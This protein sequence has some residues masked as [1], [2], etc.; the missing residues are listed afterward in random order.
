GSRTTNAQ[1]WK[2]G[3]AKVEITPEKPM[4]MSGYASRGK[5]A[6]GK[7]TPLWAKSLALQDAEGRKA[8]LV[9]MDL[10]G[11]DRGLGQEIRKR[12]SRDLGLSSEAIALCTSHTHCGPVVGDNL[13]SMYFLDEE[14]RKLVDEYAET[15]RDKIIAAVRESVG[16]LAPAEL[17]WSSGRST[18]AVNRR[19]NRGDVRQARALG[20]LKGPVDHDV[21]VLSVRDPDGKLKAVVFG[22]AC[23]AT[24][25]SFQQWCGDW[26]G[27]AQAEVEKTHPE[28]VAMFWAG[29]GADQNPLPRRSVEL[30]QQYGR[31]LAAAVEVELRGTPTPVEPRLTTSYQEI[32][33]DYAELPSRERLKQDAE[34][35]NRFLASRA[36]MLL[37]QWD[38]EG[39]LRK[40]YPYP[41]QIWKLGSDVTFVLLGGEVTVGYALRL[42]KEMTGRSTWVAGYSNDVMAYIPTL[43]VLREGGYEGGGAMLYYGLPSPWAPSVESKIINEVHRQRK[44]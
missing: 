11:I 24:T 37:K 3:A 31:Q 5:P 35:K 2:A 7:L 29:C 12:L 4:W 39:G 36:K 15:L 25:L 22:Y 17:F 33:L 14:Q 38:D 10:I 41:V 40:T 8:V 20:R 16:K 44:Q 19:N 42:K 28:A 34:S 43:K 27:F 9:T 1:G 18:F 6:E 23:H 32:D 26:P 13:R 21:P 30:A